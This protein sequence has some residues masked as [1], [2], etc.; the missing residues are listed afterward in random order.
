[1]LKHLPLSLN[2][3]AIPSHESGGSAVQNNV[4]RK[5]GMCLVTLIAQLAPLSVSEY[6]LQ[7]SW[8]SKQDL[9]YYRYSIIYNETLE[10]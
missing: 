1:M 6:F 4:N 3:M 5:L 2:T 10:S 8:L 7:S 9:K